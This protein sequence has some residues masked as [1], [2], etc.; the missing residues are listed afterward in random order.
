MIPYILYELMPFYIVILCRNLAE[1][2]IRQEIKDY[3]MQ[4]ARGYYHPL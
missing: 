1:N 4:L 2:I 3:L